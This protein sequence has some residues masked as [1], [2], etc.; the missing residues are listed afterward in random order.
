MLMFGFCMFIGVLLFICASVI[1]GGEGF[2]MPS[3]KDLCKS[4]GQKKTVKLASLSK[5]KI[6]DVWLIQLCSRDRHSIK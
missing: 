5:F 1:V 3:L 2:I 4:A 6:R